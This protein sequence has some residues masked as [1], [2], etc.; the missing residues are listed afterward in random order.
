MTQLLKEF[1]NAHK[2]IT[3][4]LYEFFQFLL[5]VQGFYWVD[6][7]TFLFEAEEDTATFNAYVSNIIDFEEK[8]NTIKEKIND[9]LP[10]N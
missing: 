9:A 2:E 4:E 5:S 1:F 7:E 8:I 3:Q 6:D 10:N